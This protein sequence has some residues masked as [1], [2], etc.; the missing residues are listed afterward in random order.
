M[1]HNSD[2]GPKPRSGQAPKE[3]KAPYR[4]RSADGDKPRGKPGSKPGAKGKSDKP[5]GRGERVAKALARA[6]V[7]S[8][9][10]VER[11]I[12]LGKVAVNGRI[13]DTPATF[14]QKDDILTVDGKVVEGAEATRVW[15]YHKP[16]GLMTTHRDPEGRPTVFE[17]L[18]EGLPRVISIG[19]LDFNTEG[20]LLLTNDGELSRALE[21]PSTGWKRT[22]R[23]RAHGRVSQAELDR[24]QDGIEVDGIRYGS[25]D[26]KLD[27]AKE[28]AEGGSNVW[29]TLT[30]TEGKYREVR[31]VLEALGLQV[32]RLIRLAYGPFQ[33][34]TLGVGE[35]E[36]VGPRVIREQLADL[37]APENLPT[38]DKVLTPP[39]APSRRPIPTSALA[40]PKAKPSRVKENIA[41]REAR[42]AQRMPKPVRI[43]EDRP[44]REGPGGDRGRPDRSGSDRPRG[45]RSGDPKRDYGK[46]REDRDDRPKRAYSPRAE[47]AE[48][49]EGGGFRPWENATERAPRE[50]GDRAFKPR[51]DRPGGGDRKPGWAKAGPRAEGDRPARAYKPREGGDDRPRGDRPA[52]PFKPREG[53]DR[54]EGGKR[55][56][57]GKPAGAGGERPARAYKPREGGAADRPRAERSDGGKRPF[58]DKPGGFKRGPASRGPGGP[59]GPPKGP[60]GPRKP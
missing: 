21:L 56:Y 42:E 18:P 37:I 43:G 44:R 58:G 49:R 1:V 11:L 4:P 28:K 34:G 23:A 57:A 48:P 8:R 53:G 52:R 22:Y 9:R 19:R 51:G 10:D 27:K 59:K 2:S 14:I 50:G 16:V 12:G 29:I 45:S 20:L 36:E 13:I 35:V 3:G 60:R 24:L 30:V 38:G 39:P 31:K 47:G 54:P 25:I 32:N 46:P 26:A 40:N 6:G 55:P 15:R 41:M 33:L 17:N 5:A 7:A